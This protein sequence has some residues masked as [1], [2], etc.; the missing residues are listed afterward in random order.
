VS[1]TWRLSVT[2]KRGDTGSWISAKISAHTQERADP[3][4]GRCFT[5]LASSALLS[6]CDHVEY[7]SYPLDIALYHVIC[8]RILANTT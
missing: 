4:S 6:P 3:I 8:N 7:I 1:D 5:V 2:W